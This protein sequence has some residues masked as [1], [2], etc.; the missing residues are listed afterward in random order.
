MAWKE[1][2]ELADKAIPY[3]NAIY[4][5]IF[6]LWN[7]KRFSRQDNII[8]DIEYHVDVELQLQNGI[9][10]LGQEKAL[11]FEFAH[12][13]TFT[14]EFYQN[15]YTKERGEFFNLGAQFYLHSYWNKTETGFLKWYMVKIFDFLTYLNRE[16][17]EQLE[18]Q[19]R[20]SS[21]RASFYWVNYE[22]IPNN[23]IYTRS[24]QCLI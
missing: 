7:I 2:K 21:S 1:D 23:F 24:N 15:R 3:Q 19:T 8:L 22:S 6:D 10:L 17:I 13:N 4:G 12:Y 14:I 16:P 9:K 18:K 5:E 20:P 11:R